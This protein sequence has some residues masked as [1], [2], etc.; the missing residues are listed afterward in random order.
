MKNYFLT[1]LI[2]IFTALTGF[3]AGA[4]D[5]GD[6][7][8][9]ANLKSLI[10]AYPDS[11]LMLMDRAETMQ[12]MPLPQYRIDLMRGLAYNE[13]RMFKLVEKYAVK[14]LASDSIDLVPDRK[15]QALLMLADARSFYGNYA[16]SIESSVQALEL[17]RRAGN[18]PAEYNMLTN[19]AGV[20]FE[21]GDLDAGYEYLDQVITTGENS[22]NVRD[23]ANVSAAIGVKVL[24]LY[25]DDRFGEALAE[26]D[27][28]LAVIDRIDAIGGAP[29][30]FTDQQRA[31]TYAR[32]ASSARKLGRIDEADEAYKAFLATEYGNTVNGRAYISDYLIESGMWSQLLDN[33]MPLFPLFQQTDT[34]NDDFRSLLWATAQAKSGLGDYRAANSLLTR[35]MAVQDSLYSREKS[36]RAQE[37]A[38]VFQL[39]E[40]DMQ[41]QKSQAESKRRQILMFAAIGI[42][43]MILI[44]LLIVLRFYRNTLHRNKI[45][46]RQINELTAEREYIYNS[47]RNA[48]AKQADGNDVP[49]NSEY[50]EFIRMESL[51]MEKKLFLSGLNRD[52]LAELTG[53]AR[54]QVIHLIQKYAGCTPAEYVNR[55]KIDYSIH[56][57]KK[58]PD[59]SIDAIAA[60]AG[61]TSRNT[62]YNN[63]NKIYGLTPAQY[64]KQLL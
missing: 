27:R 17:A 40:K 22:E 37:L 3:R 54:S 53:L 58:H 32:I 7:Y 57:M 9:E 6:T 1:G 55:L 61:Y 41:L 26:G 49:V 47:T 14:A 20:S 28:R 5:S 44:V 45:A 63:F 21:M 11:L 12:P 59:W 43:V 25:T 23:L 60:D 19:M 34:I 16:G 36:N 42:G 33:M 30:G 50:A 2:L 10:V 24:Q 48:D 64:R 52:A 38:A 8:S 35:A 13:K 18:R 62:Y 39:D 29:Q 31:Y 56:L 4:A 15:M 46:A 51:I